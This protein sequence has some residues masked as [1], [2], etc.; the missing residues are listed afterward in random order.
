M[1]ERNIR[2]RRL[3]EQET[4]EIAEMIREMGPGEN[5]FVN[6][7]Y[8]ETEQG[9]AQK[10]RENAQIAEG[11]NLPPGLVR[12]RIYWLYDGDVPVG[13]GKLRFELTEALREHGGHIGYAIRPSQRGKGYGVDMLRSLLGEA[14]NIG[15]DRVLLTC[16]AGNAAS[17]RIIERCGGEPD[18]RPGDSCKYWIE[19]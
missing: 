6:G 14:R 12:Q 3:Q 9:Y 1:N 13:Y 7:L 2:L 18:E 10:L 8:S 19:L 4:P 15:L 5:G 17:R 16:D 11:D